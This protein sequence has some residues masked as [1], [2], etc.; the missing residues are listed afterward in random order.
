MVMVMAEPE[1]PHGTKGGN[2]VHE[3]LFSRTPQ[4]FAE[5][6]SAFVRAGQDANEPVRAVLSERSADHGPEDAC[7]HCRPRLPPAG[8]G[9]RPE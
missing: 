6:V 8:E 2:F 7:A 9:R 1:F 5:E 4:T 3:A